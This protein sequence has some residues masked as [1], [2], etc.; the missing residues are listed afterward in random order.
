MRSAFITGLAGFRL[1]AAEREFLNEARPA[2]LILF[3]RNCASPDEIRRLVADA[4]A[5]IGADDVLV[6]IDQE[7]GRVQ[8]LRPPLGRNLPSARAFGELYETGADPAVAAGRLI[9]RLLAEDL[10]GLGINCDCA[11]VLDIPVPGADGIIGDRAYSV[12]PGAVIAL[13]RAVCQG[14]MAG[15]V[16]PVIKHIPGH[17]RAGC[18]SHLALPVVDACLADLRSSDFAPFQA[19]ADMPAAM[20]AHVVYSAI[21]AQAPA[22]TSQATIGGIIRDEIG[23]SG[24]LMSDDLSMKALSGP[25]EKRAAEAIAAGCDV[26]LHCNGDIDEMRAAAAGSPALQGEALA[27]FNAAFSVT[28]AQV[29]FDAEEAVRVLERILAGGQAE[30]PEV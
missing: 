9:F 22:T 28:R 30:I 4:V 14:L 18:D 15:G 5:A 7:G 25:I 12:T 26:V 24:L 3:S 27:R 17:G 16:V 19:L 23:F 10:R 29:D 8:R 20:T 11:P 1:G 13:G 21:D 6:L 2:G